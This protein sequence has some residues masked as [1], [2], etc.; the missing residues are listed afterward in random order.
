MIDR[1]KLAALTGAVVVLTIAAG[2]CGGGSD[3]TSDSVD[4]LDTA[5]IESSLES[6]LGGSSSSFDSS[7]PAVTDVSCPDEVEAAAGT[8]FDCELTGEQGLT[9]SITVT[10]K[11]A[12]GTSFKYKGQQESNGSS[13]TLSGS[14]NAS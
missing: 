4:S 3:A 10:L 9:G 8:T 13:V 7:T 2:G 14:H 1:F 12:T 11:N 5:D 6:S